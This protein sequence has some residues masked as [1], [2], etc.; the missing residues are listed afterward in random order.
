MIIMKIYDGEIKY[1]ENTQ[2]YGFFC[3]NVWVKEKL[4]DGDLIDIVVNNAFYR[5]NVKVYS[6]G[7]QVLV[8]H[9]ISMRDAAQHPAKY[10]APEIPKN[11]ELTKAEERRFRIKI[12]MLAV[13]ISVA[14]SV[15]LGLIF[16]LIGAEKELPFIYRLIDL[17]SYMFWFFGAGIAIGGALIAFT[18]L[19][20]DFGFGFGIA[21]Y[22]GTLVLSGILSDYLI[23]DENIIRIIS[24]VFVALV[25]HI[26]LL[27]RELKEAKTE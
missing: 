14:A 12:G 5:T 17:S 3:N 7:G 26:F 16:L 22:Y 10:H 23:G 20:P 27:K 2:S 11:K 15:F 19:S 9:Q 1:N 6:F 18:N 4:E 24:F 25:C 8:P 21:Y 13:L